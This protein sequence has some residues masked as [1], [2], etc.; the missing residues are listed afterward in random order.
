MNATECIL[1]LHDL[2]VMRAELADP[3]GVSRLR[4]LGFTFPEAAELERA[5]ERLVAEAEPRW[6]LSYDRARVRYGRGIGVVRSRACQGCHI[7]L[8]TRA[9]PSE[10]QPLTICE[11]CGRI[12]YWR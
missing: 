3:R 10:V 4:K 6:L 9:T 1:A 2:D 5:R 8:P 11:S 7:T 12:L